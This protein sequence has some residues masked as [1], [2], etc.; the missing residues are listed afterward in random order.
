MA[1]RKLVLY[2]NPRCTKSREALALLKARGIEPEVIEYLKTPP[3]ADE[4]KGLLKALGGKPSALL[5]TKEEPY[6]KLHL[7]ASST[8]DEVA[9]AIA[10]HP[11]L[12][13]RPVLVAGGKAVIGRPPE[14][15]L[16]LL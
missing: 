3:S 13:E 10:A 11:I 4:V 8:A 14:R 5:R 9:R 1:P 12:L 6:A 7:S 16:E 2:H 15:V